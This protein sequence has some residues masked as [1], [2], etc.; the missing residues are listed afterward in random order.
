[1]DEERKIL[2]KKIAQDLPDVVLND[3]QLCDFELLATGVFSPLTGFML[4]SDYE[5][6]MDRMRLQNGLL[7]PRAHLP[8]CFRNA[9]QIPGG[10]ASPLAVRDP[11]G[12]LLAV[13][14]V[15]DVWPVDPEKEMLRL[16][17]ESG[18]CR[19]RTKAG[20]AAA[21][22]VITRAAVWK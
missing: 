19:C 17:G 12:F 6:V 18:H 15:E 3:R 14:H 2:L 4:R 7:W 20:W 16:Q 1:M 9:G 5:S 8:G 22:A 13:M 10:P 21:R 11:E